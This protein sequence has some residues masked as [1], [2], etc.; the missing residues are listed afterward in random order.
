MQER[1]RSSLVATAIAVVVA[2]VAGLVFGMG[3]SGTALFVLAMG[4]IAFVGTLVISSLIARGRP[5]SPPGA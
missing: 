4:A 3:V 1:V 2:L 5:G